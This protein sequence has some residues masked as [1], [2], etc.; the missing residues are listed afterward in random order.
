MGGSTFVVVKN[1]D[2]RFEPDRVFGSLRESY[3]SMKFWQGND[4]HQLMAH[5]F[6]DGWEVSLN[7]ELTAF[8]IE[9][10]PTPAIELIAWVRA[11][12]PPDVQLEIFN[13][14]LTYDPAPLPPEVDAREIRRRFFPDIE[15]K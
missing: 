10:P 13:S 3:S 9:A 2:W 11:Y 1:S 12:T 6:A 8:I 5:G 4:S 15:V 14:Q 7:E